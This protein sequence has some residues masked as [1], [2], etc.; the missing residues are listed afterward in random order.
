MILRWWLSQANQSA[1][2]HHIHLPHSSV[3]E[4]LT[5]RSGIH[6]GKHQRTV[7]ACRFARH[8]FTDANSQLCRRTPVNNNFTDSPHH[9]VPTDTKNPARTAMNELRTENV[10]DKGCS[11]RA[12]AHSEGDARAFEHGGL[13][14]EEA[15]AEREGV[16]REVLRVGV[17]VALLGYIRS[18]KAI[19]LKDNSYCNTV[20]AM[21]LDVY[22]C[23]SLER[24]MGIVEL[25]CSYLAVAGTSLK[26][27]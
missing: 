21:L 8:A 24:F 6:S 15:M 2:R 22:R 4:F 16:W 14:V 26:V 1:V 18:D 20:K 12:D 27:R 19:L 7:S 11:S 10:D 3:L 9:S 25:H 17:Q 23:I 13:S 5:R